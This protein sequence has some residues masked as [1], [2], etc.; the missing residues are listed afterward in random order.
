MDYLREKVVEQARSWLGRNEKDKSFREIINVY[1]N[2]VSKT[3]RKIKMDYKW[4]WCACFWSAVAFNLGYESVMPV[5]MSC[6]ELISQAKKSGIWV[7]NDGYVPLPGDAVLYDWNDDGKGDCVGPPDHVGIVEYVNAKAG[8]FVVIEGNYDDSVKR[9][10]VLINGLHV[11]GFIT[12]KYT[13]KKYSIEIQN[14]GK[15]VD[16]VAHEVISGIWGNGD[17]RV[18]SLKEYGYDPKEIQKRVNEILNGDAIKSTT[19]KQNDNRPTEQKITASATAKKFAKS[20]SGTYV[21]TAD[22]YLRHD[23]GTNKKAICLIPKGFKAQCYGYYNLE[24]KNLNTY[25][26]WL[27]IQV[28]INGVLYTGFSCGTYLKKV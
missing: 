15:T 19:S 3:P 10:T 20:V 27:Y 1:N 7:E 22:L 13:Y 26:K 23:S 4:P 5:E 8:Y 6:S 16:T 18:N 17:I 9:R 12:P 21:T 25:V 28:K 11:R 24:V 2:N 14:G